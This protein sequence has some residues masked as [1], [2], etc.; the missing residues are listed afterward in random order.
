MCTSVNLF[1]SYIFVKCLKKVNQVRRFYVLNLEAYFLFCVRGGG[2]GR[3]SVLGTSNVTSRD[4]KSVMPDDS[5]WVP[6]NPLF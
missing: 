6:F 4:P 2:W 1:F 3:G 5:Q